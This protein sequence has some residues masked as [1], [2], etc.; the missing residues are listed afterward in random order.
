M[1]IVHAYKWPK[2]MSLIIY[3]DTVKIDKLYLLNFSSIVVYDY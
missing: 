1:Y 3:S 2:N